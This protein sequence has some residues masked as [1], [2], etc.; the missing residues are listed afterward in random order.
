MDDYAIIRGTERGRGK[1]AIV[2][3]LALVVLA[4]VIGSVVR[5]FRAQPQVRSEQSSSGFGTNV[6]AIGEL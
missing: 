4:I 2:M 5:G 3:I 6:G 1:W